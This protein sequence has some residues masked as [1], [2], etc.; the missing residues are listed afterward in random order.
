MRL[1]GKRLFLRDTLSG[2][3]CRKDDYSALGQQAAPRQKTR[4][5]YL[6]NLRPVPSKVSAP[7]AISHAALLGPD[8][9]DMTTP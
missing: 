5:L 4:C 1:S 3:T 9:Q 8:D 6:D 2:H 7:D